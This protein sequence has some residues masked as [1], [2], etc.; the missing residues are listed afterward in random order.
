MNNNIVLGICFLIPEGWLIYDHF[1]NITM[2]YHDKTWLNEW[3]DF[4]IY[5]F[6][7][8]KYTSEYKDN[9]KILSKIIEPSIDI[10]KCYYINNQLLAVKLT[11]WLRLFQIICKKKIKQN[12]LKCYFNNIKKREIYGKY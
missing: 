9:S 12:K 6:Q 2:F 5:N 11:I 8:I 3:K 1:E 10:I 7:E 4:F